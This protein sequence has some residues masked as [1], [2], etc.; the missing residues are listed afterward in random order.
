MYRNLK[1]QYVFLGITLLGLTYPFLGG[2]GE[3]VHLKQLKK[4]Y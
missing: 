1:M 2:G 3:G 4:V